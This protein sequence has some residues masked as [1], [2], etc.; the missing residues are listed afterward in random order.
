MHSSLKAKIKGWLF[1]SWVLC[2]LV[3]CNTPGSRP[4]QPTQ[5]PGGALDPVTASA[6]SQGRL[7][8]RTPGTY[9]R[10]FCPGG[11]WSPCSP[12]QPAFS[13]SLPLPTG[14]EV[15]PPQLAAPSSQQG[16]NSVPGRCCCLFKREEGRHR[17]NPRAPRAARPTLSGTLSMKPH[18]GPRLV[19]SSRGKGWH[20]GR[21][22]PDPRRTL[23]SVEGHP[24][25]AFKGIL[26]ALHLPL[27]PR[28]PK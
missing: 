15:W 18:S 14:W 16:V 28:P 2:A 26:V 27:P 9:P 24:P 21:G 22:A 8:L 25:C 4:P 1:P 12:L 19:P 3:A 11:N 23:L 20:A 13:R 10:S 5:R 6:Q 17:V 7:V